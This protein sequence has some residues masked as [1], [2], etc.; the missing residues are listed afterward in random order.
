MSKPTKIV[1]LEEDE[2]QKT[3]G[4]EVGYAKPPK[5]T[6]FKKG[7][8]GNPRGRRPRTAYEE[9]DF[10]I[11]SYMLEPVPVT[12]G[13]KQQKITRYDVLL[14]KLVSQAMNG[15]LGSA[16]LLIQATGGLKDVR[17]EWKRQKTQAD[18]DAIEQVLREADAWFG[19]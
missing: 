11:R 16:R 2:G 14:M 1:H 10:P 3:D 18:Q 15:N 12:I 5:A 4:Y 6:Q 13:G 8:S 19:E 17:E 9:D 7:Q